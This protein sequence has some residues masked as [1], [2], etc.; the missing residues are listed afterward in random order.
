[1]LA[2]HINLKLWFAGRTSVD[3]SSF[4]AM[5][6]FYVRT[7]AWFVKGWEIPVAMA[8]G[9]M[10]VTTPWRA[11]LWHKGWVR[12]WICYM[13]CKMRSII[14]VRTLKQ[15]CK[16]YIAWCWPWLIG[17]MRLHRCSG[18]NLHFCR[19]ECRWISQFLLHLGRE[20][21]FNTMIAILSSASKVESLGPR[22][23]PWKIFRLQAS[24]RES[25]W[26]LICKASR[27]PHPKFNL[28]SLRSFLSYSHII[29]FL[30][31]FKQCVYM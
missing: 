27:W 28:V 24:I 10:L 5:V 20:N 29:W 8:V 30:D 9:F 13:I 21:L 22:I 26:G 17:A 31:I 1:M 15:G 23:I 7:I 12:L 18:F 4:Q 3:F 16:S 14:M 6:L 25:L 19:L 11:M 2:S